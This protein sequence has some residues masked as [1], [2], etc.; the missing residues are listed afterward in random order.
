MAPK[1]KVYFQNGNTAVFPRNE[2][3]F[4]LGSYFFDLNPESTEQ[5]KIF[6][7]PDLVGNGR[8]LV[9]LDAVAWIREYVEEETL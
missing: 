5:G 7:T 4:K 6:H 8:V 1:I 2:T 3:V 9:N